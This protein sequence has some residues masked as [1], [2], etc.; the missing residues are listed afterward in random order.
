MRIAHLS[1]VHL[2]ETRPPVGGAYTL[3]TRLV[4]YART[5]DGQ[6]R[7][8]NFRRALETARASG[9]DH[10]VLS[11][12]LTEMGSDAQF[13]VLAEILHDSGITPERITLVPGNH[14]A[15]TTVDGWARAMAGPLAAFAPSSAS[16]A[17]GKVVDRGDVAFVPV[18]ATRFQ[19]ITRAGGE[20][21]DATADALEA[22]LADPALAKKAVVL[23]QHHPPFGP[24]GRL[25]GWIDGLVGASRLASLVRQHA[26]AHILHGHLHRIAD[27]LVGG[28]RALGAP[29]VV[30]DEAEARVRLYE[31][32]GGLLE[33][34]PI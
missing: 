25:S 29:A 3:R 27:Y 10:V 16:G 9:A 21:T 32:R 20:L 4:S 30:D 24:K 1:D 22:R 6:K 26:S 7:L 5:L 11:G 15:Y 2:L 8:A 33:P 14:D 28:A 13:S 19:S 34:L 23:V 18:D 12:D 17:P 31:L